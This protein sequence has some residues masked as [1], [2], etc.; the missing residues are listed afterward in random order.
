MRAVIDKREYDHKTFVRVKL[1][2]DVTSKIIIYLNIKKPILD[3]GEYLFEYVDDSLIS[4]LS[5]LEKLFE[6]F[7]IQY[8]YRKNIL[9]EIDNFKKEQKSFNE[10]SEKAFKIRNNDFD[11]IDELVSMFKEFEGVVK[12]PE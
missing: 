7:N 4:I 5:F 1:S 10:F 6:R 2:E 11:G 12:F 8:D 9:I 3:D